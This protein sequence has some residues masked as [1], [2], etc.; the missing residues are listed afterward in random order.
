MG[1]FSDANTAQAARAKVE[2]LG[3]KTYTQEVSTPAGK[4]IRVR[5]GPYAN[6]AEADK[7]M[8]TLKKAGLVAAVLTL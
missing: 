4:K 8:A 5:V 6:K 2:K 3:I 1:A 7:A